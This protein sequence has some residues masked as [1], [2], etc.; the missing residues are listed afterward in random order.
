VAV[1]GISGRSALL[2]EATFERFGDENIDLD[3]GC[4]DFC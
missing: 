2:L 1:A 3:G 4:G